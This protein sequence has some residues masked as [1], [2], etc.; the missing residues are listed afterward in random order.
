[1]P[2]QALRAGRAP[3]VEAW[4]FR[5]LEAWSLHSALPVARLPRALSSQFSVLSSQFSVLSSQFSVLSSQF[6]V[7]SSQLFSVLSSQF[8]VLSSLFSVLWGASAPP[9]PACASTPPVSVPLCLLCGLCVL[10]NLR[11]HH[12][13]SPGRRGRTYRT[14][15]TYRTAALPLCMMTSPVARLARVLFSVAVEGLALWAC[16]LCFL[17]SGA[18]VPPLSG[19]SFC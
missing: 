5:S 10:R 14:H 9:C 3:L 6:S 16:T 18:A 12:T 19:W 17:F 15:R 2:L 13:G 11:F 4:K 8:S 7:L 1:M